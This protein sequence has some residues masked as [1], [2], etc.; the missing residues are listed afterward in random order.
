M[1]FEQ[2]KKEAIKLRYDRG[3][4]VNNKLIFLFIF[5][6]LLFNLNVKAGEKSYTWESLAYGRLPWNDEIAMWSTLRKGHTTD[7]KGLDKVHAA[8]FAASNLL[9]ASAYDL[10][11][12]PNVERVLQTLR[13]MQDEKSGCIKYYYE[14]KGI[15]DTNAAFFVARRLLIL[16][17][18]YYKE[19]TPESQ[20]L[21]DALLKDFYNWLYGQSREGKKFY[22]NKYLG[23]LVCAKLIQEMVETPKEQSEIL[24][25]NFIEAAKYWKNKNWG[26]G[27]HMSDAYGNVC[28]DLLS[29]YLLYTREKDTVVYSVYKDLFDELLEIDDIF[30]GGPRVPHIRCYNFTKSRGKRPRYRESI[31]P[32]EKVLENLPNNPYHRFSALARALYYSQ[33]WH[34]HAPE[35]K[36]PRKNIHIPCYGGVFANAYIKKNIRIGSLTEFP[37]MPTAESRW[38]GLAWQSFPLVYWIPDNDW[39]FLQWQTIEDERIKA[40]PA[41]S[42]NPNPDAKALT[43]KIVP[44]VFGK[45]Y[46]LQKK[47][48]VLA[49]R[50]MPAIVSSWKS[51][52][53]TFKIVN[54]DPESEITEIEHDS[55]WH[56]LL[57]KYPEFNVSLNVVPVRADISVK[58][59]KSK[60]RT[61]YWKTVYPKNVLGRKK[62][63]VDIWGISINGKIKNAPQIKIHYTSEIPLDDVQKP[64]SIKWKWPETTWHVAIDPMADKVLKE[65]KP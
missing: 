43:N 56:Q 27:E 20:Q 17:A 2:L 3:L 38:G 24:K 60:D 28:I 13:D 12:H 4:K 35:R 42:A 14:D 41:E 23:D 37:L 18:E 58:L 44:P 30:A 33:G 57:I 15:S 65:I 8:R 21:I 25:Q 55:N 45:T 39:A 50:I 9:L 46:S 19:F 36:S 7:T 32:L 47:G 53:D 54:N 49:V 5:F 63:I 11:D 51:V 6:S 62:M 52:S 26:W 64:M 48:D 59:E 40:H 10:L 1:E 29:Q 22:P 31:K 16:K 61:F 34:E